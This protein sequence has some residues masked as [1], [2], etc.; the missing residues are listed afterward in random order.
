M[1]S[2]ISTSRFY[3]WPN[4]ISSNQ[5]VF[6]DLTYGKHC[7]F[8]IPGSYGNATSNVGCTLCQCNGHG[9]VQK[10]ICND[11]NGHCY[12][13]HNTMGRHC[14]QCQPGFYGQPK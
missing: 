6:L 2:Q 5:F 13:I 12:C 1:Y 4:V 11:R 14:D 9:D 7:E 10:K 8:C 3:T